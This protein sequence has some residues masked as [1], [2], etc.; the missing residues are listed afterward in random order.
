MSALIFPLLAK[1]H[2]RFPQ[3]LPDL[4][5]QHGLFH[6]PNL[7]SCLLQFLLRCYS[8]TW[9]HWSFILYLPQMSNPLY[10]SFF[11]LPLN[12]FHSWHFP[13][14][15]YT[16]IVLLSICLNSFSTPIT[17]YI[18][19]IFIYHFIT[20]TPRSCI[21]CSSDTCTSVYLSIGLYHFPCHRLNMR[22]IFQLLLLYARNDRL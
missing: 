10:H 15:F 3:P 16:F 5:L 6:S 13:F 20:S 17:Q 14:S 7:L 11:N 1:F 22:N 2:P 12:R 4:S 19:K 8:F 9:F 18:P 21:T